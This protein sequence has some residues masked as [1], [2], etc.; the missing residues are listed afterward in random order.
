MNGPITPDL[1]AHVAVGVDGTD[2]ALRAVRWAAVEA[3]DRR[4]PLRVVHAAPYAAAAGPASARIE[5]ILALA[6]TVARRS[7]P[8]VTVH[9]AGVPRAPVAVLRELGEQADLLV[10]GAVGTGQP[11]DLADPLIARVAGHTANPVVV[12]H[13]TVPRHGPVVV[14][15][16]DPEREAALIGLAHTFA[17]RYG[18]SLQIVHASRPGSRDDHGVLDH[19]V[20]RW[21]ERST[22]V[23]VTLARS[24]ERPIPA[25]LGRARDARL[26]VVGPGARRAHILVGSTARALIRGA[27]C[28]VL[29][30]GRGAATA[31]LGAGH[32]AADPHLR[33][34]L[35]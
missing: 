17:E 30:G 2:A 19:L 23:E 9:T 11:Q 8:G 32:A 21:D 31:N 5:R 22:R 7:A 35:W 20:R 14:G 34:E 3:H 13:R 28:P 12:V 33:S 6:R 4:L 27:A 10:L 25:L 24:S 15:V 26:L 1:G 29:V 18:T 16:D